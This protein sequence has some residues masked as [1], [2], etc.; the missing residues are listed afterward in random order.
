MLIDCLKDIQK[1]KKS[2]LGSSKGSDFEDQIS[3]KLKKHKFEREL[4]MASTRDP[5]LKQYLKEIKGTIQSKTGPSLIDN[6]LLAKGEQYKNFFIPQPYGSQNYP[7]FLVFTEHKIFSIESKFLE[8]AGTKPVWNGNLPKQDGIYILGSYH[9]QDVTLFRGEDVLPEEERVSILKMWD[10]TEKDFAEWMKNNKDAIKAGDIK[11][12]Y[13]FTPYVRQAYQQTQKNNPAAILNY[14]K[15][16]KDRKHLE[17]S[18]LDWV[19]Q[20]DKANSAVGFYCGPSSASTQTDPTS[21]GLSSTT[22]QKIL[23]GGED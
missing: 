9:R 23:N 12:E 16:G 1:D 4:N 2:M 22:F 20:N 8:K 18:L 21:V 19:S 17:K 6:T 10:D 5:I 3:K 13:G 7:D 15:D 11:G 14:F